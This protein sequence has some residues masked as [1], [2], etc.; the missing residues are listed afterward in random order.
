VTVSDQPLLTAFPGAGTRLPLETQILDQLDI[1]D[2]ESLLNIAVS[3]LTSPE[4]GGFGR[5]A[6]A[7]CLL[8]QVLKSF[9]TADIDCRLLLLDRLNTNIQNFL[10]LLM[11]HCQEQ[12]GAFCASVN[13]A[14]RSV[15]PHCPIFP[16]SHI[17]SFVIIKYSCLKLHK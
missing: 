3:C 17:L 8:D 10:S 2:P 9:D 6:Q 11:P 1:L 15:Y 7:T 14:I 13:I 12:P 16:I 4:V 5:K